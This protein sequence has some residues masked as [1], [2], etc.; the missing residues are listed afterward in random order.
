VL[1]DLPH[2]FFHGHGVYT[3]GVNAEQ[4][5]KQLGIPAWPVVHNCNQIG[6]WYKVA[7]TDAGIIE[8]DIDDIAISRVK[9]ALLT[10]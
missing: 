3:C 7:S 4:Q 8:D 5:K 6:L 1:P 2:H 10:A 9:L